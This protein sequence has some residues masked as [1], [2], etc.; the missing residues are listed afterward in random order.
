MC[1][2]LRLSSSF[3]TVKMLSSSTL[4]EVFDKKN[5]GFKGS[6]VDI[7]RGQKWNILDIFK[8]NWEK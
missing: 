3:G 5:I 8:N 4:R 1:V 2:F 7:L 6:A